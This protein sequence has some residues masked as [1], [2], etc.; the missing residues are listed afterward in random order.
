MKLALSSPSNVAVKIHIY[1]VRYNVSSRGYLKLAGL[2]FPTIAASSAGANNISTRNEVPDTIAYGENNVANRKA[3]APALVFTTNNAR[4]ATLIAIP[5]MVNIV[6]Q[7]A[8]GH[9]SY[10]L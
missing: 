3:T 6:L 8:R 1:Q 7:P 9:R 5:T 4:T 10:S 2:A